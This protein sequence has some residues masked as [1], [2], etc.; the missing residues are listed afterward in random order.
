MV[1][2]AVDVEKPALPD[3]PEADGGQPPAK[4]ARPVWWR[5]GF[6]ETAIFEQDQYAPDTRSKGPR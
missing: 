5:D 6:E 2:G 4:G 1:T 3:E